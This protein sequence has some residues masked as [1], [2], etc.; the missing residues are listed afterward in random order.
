MNIV[1]RLNK[2]ILVMVSSGILGFMFFATAV[3]F[4]L[5]AGMSPG[6]T[7]EAGTMIVILSVMSLLAALVVL[8]TPVWY[9]FFRKGIRESNYT[10]LAIFASLFVL[11]IV[12]VIIAN[13]AHESQ[14]RGDEPAFLEVVPL[15]L[16]FIITSI[17]VARMLF[18]VLDITRQ[19]SENTYFLVQ[20]VWITS[21]ALNIINTAASIPDQ[22]ELVS[23][24]PML[25]TVF[26]LLVLLSVPLLAVLFTLLM[27]KNVSYR[28]LMSRAEPDTEERSS[29]TGLD[30][31]KLFVFDTISL[32]QKLNRS[33]ILM[34][35]VPI[36][37]VTLTFFVESYLL[38][39]SGFIVSL[40]V[41]LWYT[42]RWKLRGRKI[43]MASFVF[44]SLT[45]SY[46]IVKNF[47]VLSENGEGVSGDFMFAY[48]PLFLLVYIVLL[49]AR[50]LL[51]VNNLMSGESI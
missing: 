51:G 14:Y 26:S 10:V 40:F 20:F 13:G 2:T 41:P 48:A 15:F 18:F 36:A 47:G 32:K 50:T 27:Y 43:R 7:G 28:R 17:F 35:I 24:V 30:L 46:I 11:N 1:E 25:L 42:L 37:T 8:F 31:N 49:L 9:F 19:R 34:G 6:T 4:G 23:P 33:I 38:L 39:A 5:A 44:V 16:M 21:L 22:D 29:A 3:F 12:V 45:I